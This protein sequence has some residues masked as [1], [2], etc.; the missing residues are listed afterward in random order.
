MISI[1]CAEIPFPFPYAN[2]P[3]S[4]SH[5]VYEVLEVLNFPKG[6]LPIG[7]KS[8][9]LSDDGSF[10]VYFADEGCTFG[11]QAGY[12]L[13]YSSKVTGKATKGS[14]KNI[15]GVK[16]KVLFA[17]LSIT[18]VTRKE[19]SLQFNVGPLSASFELSKFENCP[20]CGC[21]FDCA[22]LHDA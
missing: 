7:I 21:G 10:Q 18:E 11:S 4:P 5:T 12:A 6:I 17:W 22:L 15:V 3:S 16:V 13:S 20:Q 2:P 14:I 9:T 1:S 19:G 8:Y